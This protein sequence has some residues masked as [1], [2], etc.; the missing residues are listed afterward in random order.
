MANDCTFILLSYYYQS[1]D[2]N[3]MSCEDSADYLAN[4]SH[5]IESAAI[6]AS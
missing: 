1:R 4:S 5:I 2:S 6:S 3:R